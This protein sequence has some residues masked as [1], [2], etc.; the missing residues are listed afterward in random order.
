MV[1]STAH[2]AMMLA[3]SPLPQPMALTIRVCVGIPACNRVSFVLQKSAHW[4]DEVRTGMAYPLSTATRPTLSGEMSLAAQKWTPEKRFFS[5]S[6]VDF[7]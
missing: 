4:H 2:M 6:G 7:T 3:T 1:W 5:D